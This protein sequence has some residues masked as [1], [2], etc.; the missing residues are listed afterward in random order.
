MKVYKPVKMESGYLTWGPIAGYRTLVVTFGSVEED[1]KCENDKDYEEL[2]KEVMKDFK[3]FIKDSNF[4]EMFKS[5][6]HPHIRGDKTRFLFR[7]LDSV[8]DLDARTQITK[9]FNRIT[10]EAIVE[11]KITGAKMFHP[12]AFDIE[13]KP[14]EP[15]IEGIMTKNPIFIQQ[16][17]WYRK[18]NVCLVKLD[19]DE[20]K[21]DFKSVIGSFDAWKEIEYHG[22]S[23]YGFI[24]HSLDDCA[25]IEERFIKSNLLTD[26]F[27][28]R[29]W[30]RIADDTKEEEIKEIGKWAFDHFYR[31]T[32]PL[33]GQI[34]ELCL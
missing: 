6:T 12:L 2:S 31:L 13:T 9:L 20:L 34:K 15:S 29:V 18:F 10:E 22:Q 14:L 32:T 17:S 21:K 23:H 27:P 25:F 30:I 11:D 7:G 28:G 19:V 3:K 26:Q 4:T 1:R 8:F 24:V 33:S 5:F 16:N